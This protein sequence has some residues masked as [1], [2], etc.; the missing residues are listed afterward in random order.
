[1]TFDPAI[2]AEVLRRNKYP[3]RDWAKFKSKNSHQW[4]PAMEA[5]RPRFW[6]YAEI[7]A[8]WSVPTIT[9]NDPVYS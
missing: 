8:E 6:T 4:T 5:K 9:C 7:E 3:S 1:M 2:H